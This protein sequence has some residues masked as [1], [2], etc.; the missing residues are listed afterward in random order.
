[1]VVTR[2]HTE[3][4][5]LSMRCVRGYVG[6]GG[7]GG[8]MEVWWCGGGV[9]C[10]GVARRELTPTDTNGYQRIPTD[11]ATAPGGGSG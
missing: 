3:G 2:G 7:R 6:H 1:M 5:G 8:R 4:G 9:W 11:S 10:G